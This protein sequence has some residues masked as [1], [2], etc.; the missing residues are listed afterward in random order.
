MRIGRIRAWNKR[1]QFAKSRPE[2]GSVKA[3]SV[4]MLPCMWAEW[5]GAKVMNSVLLESVQRPLRNNHVAT[6]LNPE[7]TRLADA[8]DRMCVA[9]TVPSLT[10][11]WRPH[12]DQEA[13]TSFRIGEVKMVE[14]MGERG[15]PWGVP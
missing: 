15:E 7:T 13:L 4:T 14:R 8:L 2:E 3:I 11:I 6:S 9:V 10:Y 5:G 12:W 1:H